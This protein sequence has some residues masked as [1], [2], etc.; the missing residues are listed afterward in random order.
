M[1]FLFLMKDRGT[2]AASLEESIQLL[3]KR[4]LATK[5]VSTGVII[6]LN[7]NLFLFLK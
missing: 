2:V 3:Q 7:L 5:R 1:R 6:I 4:D